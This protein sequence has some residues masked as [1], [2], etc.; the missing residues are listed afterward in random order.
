MLPEGTVSTEENMTIDERRKYLRKMK[1]RYAKARR[2]ERSRLLDEMEAVTGLHRKSLIRL[3][4]GTLERKARTRQRSATY[5]TEV[6]YAVRIIAESLDHICAERLTPSLAW[7]A[8]HLAAHGEL[9]VSLSVLEKLNAISVSTTRRILDRAGQSS[10]RLQR[11]NKGRAK[12]FAQDIPMKRLPWYERRPG[13]FEVDTVHHC[14]PS[15]S[16]DYICTVQMIDIATGWSERVAVLGRSYLVMEDAFRRIL[17]RLPFPVLEIHPDNGSEFLNHHL[18]RFWM[19]LVQGVH[20]SRSRPYHKNDNRIVEQK[21]SSLVRA[22]LGY[23]RLDTVAQTHTLNRLYDKMWIYYNL[24]QPV[25]RL[26][27][28]EWI[29]QQEGQP[30]RLRRSYDQACTPFDRLC[31]TDSITKEHKEQLAALRECTN[32]RQ[33]RQEIYDS[34]D[35]LFSLPAATPGTAENVYHTLMTHARSEQEE[36]GSLSF[37]FDRTVIL[38]DPSHD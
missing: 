33:L 5:D 3:L 22:Y 17:A 24:F 21:N 38:A 15:A 8:K 16:G 35:R 36:E 4:G 14:G 20:L 12:R 23:D 30:A 11:R 6:E 18:L 34:V 19:E 2:R 31:D 28:K 37:N 10:R 9:H 1:T 7:M 32:P 29:P 13:Y 25:M 26:A 27:E